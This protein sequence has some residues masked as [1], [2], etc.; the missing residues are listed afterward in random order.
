MEE[1]HI[2]YLG[3]G[4]NEGDREALMHRAVDLLQE[5]VGMVVCRSA[6]YETEPWGF[7]SPH[8]FLNAAVGVCTRL[9]PEEILAATQ[10]IERELGRK[11]KSTSGGYA[12]RPMDIDLLLYDNLVLEADYVLPGAEAPV[13]LSLPHPLMHQRLFVMQPLSE[14]APEAEHPV[15]HRPLRELLQAFHDRHRE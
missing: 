6:L 12:D 15:L 5:R 8:P 2:V 14:I 4:S 10:Q 11:R 9:L 13:H 1:Q 7:V 3:L